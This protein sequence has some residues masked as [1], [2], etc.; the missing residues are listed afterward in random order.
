MQAYREMMTSLM[1]QYVADI[2]L[3]QYGVLTVIDNI[4]SDKFLME[5]AVAEICG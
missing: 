5:T 1:E 3:H 4:V 2:G